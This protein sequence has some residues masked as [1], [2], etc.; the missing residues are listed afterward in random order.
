[1]DEL[2]R[3]FIQ[4]QKTGLGCAVGL[5][6]VADGVPQGV[7]GLTGLTA[8][9][10]AQHGQVLVCLVDAPAV[11][12]ACVQGGTDVGFQP[13]V[14]LGIGIQEAGDV[15]VIVHN[16]MGFAAERLKL[17]QHQRHQNPHDGQHDSHQKEAF[18]PDGQI[19]PLV[20][21]TVQKDPPA[22]SCRRIGGKLLYLKFNIAGPN[23]QCPVGRKESK[24]G[25]KGCPQNESADICIFACISRLFWYNQF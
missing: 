2:R 4:G 12:L 6:G 8:P 9:L 23:P 7:F 17:N 1:M 11:V 18:G 10:G 3:L 21:Q 16:D 20:Q 24:A 19:V 14:F 13:Y 25:E 22:S 5:H 15:A